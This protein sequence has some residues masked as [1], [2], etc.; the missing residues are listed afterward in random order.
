MQGR[1]PV[2]EYLKEFEELLA[3]AQNDSSPS[4]AVQ[5][6]VD[7]FYERRMF[8]I[9]RDYQRQFQFTLVTLKVYSVFRGALRREIPVEDLQSRLSEAAEPP[10]V[11]RRSGRSGLFV[12]YV[13]EQSA[14]GCLDNGETRAD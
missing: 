1:E 11:R 4:E 8:D 9:L 5:K 13:W 2:E 12:R 10:V 6:R 7:D 14:D 3:F